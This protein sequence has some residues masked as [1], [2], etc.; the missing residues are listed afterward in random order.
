MLGADTEIRN[1]PLCRFI[2][3]QIEQH[4]HEVDHIPL[5]SAAEAEEIFLVQLQARIPVIVERAASHTISVYFQPVM[6]GGLLHADCRLDGFIDCHRK[7]SVHN[8]LESTKHP[9]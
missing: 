6:F 4:C 9:P 2:A 1:Q 7:T 5:G 8:S 3:A